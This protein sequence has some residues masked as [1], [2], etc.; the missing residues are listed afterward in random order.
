VSNRDQA[1][2][3]H[4]FFYGMKSREIHEMLGVSHDVVRDVIRRFRS[5]LKD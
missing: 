1:I 5:R 4:Y 2:L 3:N